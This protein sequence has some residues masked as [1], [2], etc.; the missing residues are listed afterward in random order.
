MSVKPQNR[1]LLVETIQPEQ[2]DTPTILVPDD[3]AVTVADQYQL[4]R[5]LAAPPESVY[6][7][8]QC[9]IVE[10]HMIKSVSI[11]GCA[12]SCLVLENYVLALVEDEAV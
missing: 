2:K 1:H 10:G 8:G 3:Y 7:P 12:S 11:D 9:A 5:I 6:E 4:V